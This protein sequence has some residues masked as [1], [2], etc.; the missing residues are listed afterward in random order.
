L[1]IGTNNSKVRAESSLSRSGSVKGRPSG[2]LVIQEEDEDEEDGVEVVEE[3]SPVKP[4]EIAEIT[5]ER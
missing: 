3:F 5:E 1:S 4:G 2:E